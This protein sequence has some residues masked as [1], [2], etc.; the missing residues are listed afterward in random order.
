MSDMQDFERVHNQISLLVGEIAAGHGPDADIAG[1]E[2]ALD[3]ASRGKFSVAVVGAMNCGK[4]TLLN[5][6]LGREVLPASPTA[7]SAKLVTISEAPLEVA[8]VHFLTSADWQDLTGRS[9]RYHRSQ[10]SAV[11]GDKVDEADRAAVEI[12]DEANRKLGARTRDWLDAGV[13]EIPFEQLAQYVAKEGAFTPVVGRVD[14]QGPFGLDERLIF[15]DTPGLFD[16]VRA[17]ELETQRRLAESTAVLLV[18]YAGAAVSKDEVNFLK[19]RLVTVGFERIVPVVNK[20]DVIDS[21]QDRDRVRSYV[22]QRLADIV[23]ELRAAGIKPVLLGALENASPVPVS[24]LMALVAKT[25]GEVDDA[26]FHEERWRE[27]GW[28]F[29]TYDDLLTLSGVA[30]LQADTNAM[31]LARDGRRRLTDPLRKVQGFLLTQQSELKLEATENRA[32]REDLKKSRRAIEEEIH[33]LQKLEQALV[34]RKVRLADIADNLLAGLKKAAEEETRDILR[35]TADTA[36]RGA[37]RDAGRDVGLVNANLLYEL[38]SVSVEVSSVARRNLQALRSD[39]PDELRREVGRIVE[40]LGFDADIDEYHFDRLQ[41]IVNA[42]IPEFEAGSAEAATDSRGFWARMPLFGR[43]Q[44]A[45]IMAQLPGI[46]DQWQTERRK[47][48]LGWAEGVRRA[49]KVQYV[50]RAV[51]DIGASLARAIEEKRE[52]LKA[53]AK[54]GGVDERISQLLGASKEVAA[55]LEQVGEWLGS[56]EKIERALRSWG[57]EGGLDSDVGGTT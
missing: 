12:V 39:L 54:Q 56:V 22:R 19:R 3:N 42:D 45:E 41:W 50:D 21:H 2:T 38:R 40:T 34:L 25:R 46:L 27:T 17:R 47:D 24:G 29:D 20:F 28:D 16:P 13:K 9:E 52:T 53:Q 57:A 6:L 55:K 15:V 8:R 11:P 51:A 7:C 32:A 26:D 35:R 31:V 36:K 5:A 49:V 37:S 1:I 33:K 23:G 10:T 4:S 43:S 18:M 48:V 14:L 30:T 44:S